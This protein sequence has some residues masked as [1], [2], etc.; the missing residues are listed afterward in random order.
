MIDAHSVKIGPFAVADMRQQEVASFIATAPTRPLVAY[1]IHAGGL[2]ERH[3]VPFIEAMGSAD[4][5]Y[6]DGISIVALG[7]L[8]GARTIER[9]PTT[10]L[11]WTVMGLMA[12]GG[13]PVRVALIGGPPGLAQRAARTIEARLPVDVV[14]T[15]HGYHADWSEPLSQLRASH[16]DLVVVGLGMPLEA[17]WATAHQS[18]LPDAVIMT[19][20]GWLGFLAGHE[21]RAPRWMRGLHLEWLHR[22]LQDPRRLGPRYAKAV[23]S[24]I[25]MLGPALRSSRAGRQ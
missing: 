24:L 25:A 16:P 4:I 5:V 9:A 12:E 11:G 15:D 20:G 22:L 10:D 17:I 14:H 3:N 19:C 8:A 6:A 13:G 7:R 21:E 18:E 2:N 1:A 23:L